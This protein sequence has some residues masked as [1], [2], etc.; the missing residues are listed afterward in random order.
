MNDSA[1]PTEQPRQQGL[2]R[3]VAVFFYGIAV[4][5]LFTVL[6]LAT[7][8]ALL[9]VPGLERRRR[10]TPGAARLFLRVAGM[11]P[12][13]AGIDRLP[14]GQCVVVA[15]HAS[16]L[17]GVIMK[18]VLPPRFAFV[19]KREADAFPLAGLLLRRIGTEFVERFNRHR[20]ALDARRV[21]RSASGGQPLVF[22]PEGT[23]IRERGLLK[24]HSGA[25]ATAIR[26]RCP[27]VP[28]V[29]RGSRALLPAERIL[30]QPGP[31]EVEFI[32]PQWPGAADEPST[33]PDAIE[34]RDRCRRLILERL[35]EPDLAA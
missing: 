26:A 8:L 18:A 14:P 22:F 34:L 35:D 20:G 32:E 16:Y 24:F 25:F 28:V 7:L 13:V 2:A 12:R 29:I 21:L 10:A 6:A 33:E 17:D 4:C 11:S 31:L 5:L 15:N 1:V 3:R 27:V 9:V 23:F 30:P 19:V